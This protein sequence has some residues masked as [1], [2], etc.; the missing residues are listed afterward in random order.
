MCGSLSRAR[1]SR[2]DNNT[3]SNH[4]LSLSRRRASNR[5][6]GVEVSCFLASLGARE[7]IDYRS[8]ADQAI[9]WILSSGQVAVDY[10]VEV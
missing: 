4:F 9:H 7:G 1:P 2:Q 10:R 3:Q 6:F 8:A 5:D